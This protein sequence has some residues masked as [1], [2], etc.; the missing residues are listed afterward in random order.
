VPPLPIRPARPD[1][2]PAVV[3]L[4]RGLADFENLPGPDDG[5]AARMAADLARGDR[6]RLLVADS[7]EGLRGY[8]LYFFTYSTFRARPVVFLEDLFVVPAARGQG[9]GEALLRSVAKDGVAAGCCRFE[10]SVL[11]WNVD[12]QR[13]Y[14]RLGARILAEWH[15]CR[16]DGNELAALGGPG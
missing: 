2:V 9:L 15:I 16:V 1:D 3:D 5:A 14:R 13:F 6:F 11:D 10:W 4:I 12:A 8:A 7:P